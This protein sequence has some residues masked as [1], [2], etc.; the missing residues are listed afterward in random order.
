MEPV[1]GGGGG[2]D[3]GPGTPK[4]ICRFV[5]FNKEMPLY[6]C[7]MYSSNVLHVEIP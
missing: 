1:G 4:E 2:V 3:L 7:C 5:F 6:M